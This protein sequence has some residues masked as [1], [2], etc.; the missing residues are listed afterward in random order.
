[1]VNEIH[2]LLNE[3]ERFSYPF[4]DRLKSIP[5]NGI[6]VQ[7]EKGEKFNQNDRIVRVGTHNGVNQL[8]SRLFQHFT[9]ENQR[10]SIFRKNI[11]RC[12]LNKEKNPYLKFWNLELTSKAEKEKNMH[13]VDL[14]LEKEI[15][16]RISVYVQSNFSFAVFEVETEE[17]RIFWESKL[18]STLAFQSK[19]SNEWL[20]NYSTKE[21]IKQSGLW[22]IQCLKNPKLT[23][24]EFE[25][26]KKII[27]K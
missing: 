24:D 4:D 12:F 3:M 17:K 26:L 9:N 8:H 2:L 6:Y 16:K 10:R 5:Y 19:P 21:K 25:E 22:Q 20:G 7:F 1:M 11:G 23:K 27:I 14:E 13:L 18:I 15:E